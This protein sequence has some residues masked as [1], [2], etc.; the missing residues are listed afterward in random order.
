ML[1]SRL[2]LVCLHASSRSSIAAVGL[3]TG[4][5]SP[6]KCPV[7]YRTIAAYEGRGYGFSKV[8]SLV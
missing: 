2:D 4:V 1:Y 6:P 7:C 5:W 3:S 8:R